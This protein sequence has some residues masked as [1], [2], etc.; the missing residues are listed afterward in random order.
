MS[1]EPQEQPQKVLRAPGRVRAL[2]D[3][4]DMLALWSECD[5]RELSQELLY[6]NLAMAPDHEVVEAHRSF[7]NKTNAILASIREAE[8]K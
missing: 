1:A 2:N 7:A 8:A 3:I 4:M 6:S 5:L